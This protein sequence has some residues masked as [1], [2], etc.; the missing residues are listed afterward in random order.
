MLCFM[1]WYYYNI[2]N[3]IHYSLK[4]VDILKSSSQ[5]L[6]SHMKVEPI[7]KTIDQKRRHET[8]LKQILIRQTYSILHQEP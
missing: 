5:I 3:F 1:I 8:F 2:K 7:K 4:L 6:L